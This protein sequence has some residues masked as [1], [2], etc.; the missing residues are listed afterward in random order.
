MLLGFASRAVQPTKNLSVAIII[1]FVHLLLHKIIKQA[2]IFNAG[3]FITMII[4]WINLGTNYWLEMDCFLTFFLFSRINNIL[5]IFWTALKLGVAIKFRYCE[6]ATKLEKKS[7]CFLNYLVPSKQ[8]GRF[9]TFFV[10]FSENLNFSR[11][12]L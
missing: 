5:F 6:K 10:A 4:I 7:L 9:F 1:I 12:M 3:R 11:K 2:I 8:S